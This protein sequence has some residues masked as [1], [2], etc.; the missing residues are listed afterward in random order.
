VQPTQ[1]TALAV[2]DGG[3]VVPGCARPLA[4]CEA[5]RLWPWLDGGPTDLANLVLVW[6]AHYRAVHEGGWRRQRQ[7][8][9]RLTASP[10]S[11]DPDAIPTGDTTPPPDPTAAEGGGTDQRSDLSGRPPKGLES[12][13]GASCASTDACRAP[14]PLLP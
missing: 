11:D 13:S 12:V 7:P 2:R 9:G 1:C 4:W 10:P 6:R 5:H 8:D 14:R 3:C